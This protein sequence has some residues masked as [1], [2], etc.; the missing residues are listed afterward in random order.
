MGDFNVNIIKSQSTY[1][2][3]DRDDFINLLF[4]YNGNQLIN[5][6]TRLNMN[7]NIVVQF[8]DMPDMLG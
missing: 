8:Y 6:L 1:K 7:L 2:H 5:I 3:K 4:F